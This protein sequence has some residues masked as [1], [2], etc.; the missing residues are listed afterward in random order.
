LFGA[1]KIPDGWSYHD[2]GAGNHLCVKD[3]ISKIVKEMSVGLEPVELY[4]QWKVIVI[5][6]ID[7]RDK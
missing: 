7:L 1:D 2:M 5:Q 4:Q 3:N 6:A